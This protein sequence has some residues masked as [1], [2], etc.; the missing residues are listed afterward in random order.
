MDDE[1]KSMIRRKEA[2]LSLPKKRP[3]LIKPEGENVRAPTV[4][5]EDKRRS[6]KG[7]TDSGLRFLVRR[8]LI[9]IP[10]DGIS[11]MKGIGKPKGFLEEVCGWI[12]DILE[13][14]SVS[15]EEEGEGSVHVEGQSSYGI[16]INEDEALSEKILY[17]FQNE[18]FPNR[19]NVEV[20]NKDELKEEE[21]KDEPF[22]II[23]LLKEHPIQNIG[24]DKVGESDTLFIL[25]DLPHIRKEVQAQ[26]AAPVA[27]RLTTTLWLPWAILSDVE[28]DEGDGEVNSKPSRPV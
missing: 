25:L 3:C 19:D 11:A 16:E 9:L 6:I 12:L 2:R 23:Q 7:T 27:E 14:D 10:S 8:V 18:E 24:L 20:I 22:R 4:V 1:W 5:G 13:E 17:T 21:D 26:H 28:I 15:G